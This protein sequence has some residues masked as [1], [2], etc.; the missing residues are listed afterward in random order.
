MCNSVDNGA[1]K[2]C[3]TFKPFFGQGTIAPSLYTIPEDNAIKVD[4]LP[5]LKQF[6]MVSLGASA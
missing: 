4:H 1:V 2:N 5:Q 6:H 3:S